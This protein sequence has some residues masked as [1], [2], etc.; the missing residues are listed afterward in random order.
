LDAVAAARLAQ[1]F[2]Q[3]LACR[4]VHQPHLPQIPLHLDVPANPS[5]R[6][7]VVSRFHFHAAVQ[8]HRA[9]AVLVVAERFDGQRQ[10]GRFLLGEHDRDLTLGGAVD[11]RV[12]PPR[13]PMVQV[14][15]GFF[16]AFEA[17]TFQRRILGMTDAPF[18]LPLAIR[19]GDPAR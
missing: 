7:A 2:A 4:G 8:M 10:Q 19:I 14:G 11:A 15:L 17:Q 3:Q 6:R 18:H 16:E 1:V 5:R 12:G 9:L 13:F